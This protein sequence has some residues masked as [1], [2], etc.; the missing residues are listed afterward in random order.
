MTSAPLVIFLSISLRNITSHE[1]IHL[2]VGIIA[3]IKVVC[4]GTESAGAPY[5]ATS[6]KE[7]L[8]KAFEVDNTYCKRCLY[9]MY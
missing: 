5:L 8:S 1:S 4:A 6:K 7:G 2:G 3:D 9:G